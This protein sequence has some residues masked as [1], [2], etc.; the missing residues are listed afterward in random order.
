M[1]HSEGLKILFYHVDTCSK[2]M[3][4]RQTSYG[5]KAKIK[6]YFAQTHPLFRSTA[7]HFHL[8]NLRKE[9]LLSGNSKCY[10][11]WLT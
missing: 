9:K 1:Q 6:L 3:S 7:K 10:I 4:D 11:S 2:A 8:S 5:L